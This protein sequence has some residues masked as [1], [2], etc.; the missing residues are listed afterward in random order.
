MKIKTLVE[1]LN[2]QSYTIQEVADKTGTSY[3]N[4]QRWLSDGDIPTHK[5]KGTQLID[6]TDV[7]TYIRLKTFRKKL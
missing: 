4:V 3:R 1:K 2:N 5:V 7:P 6:P